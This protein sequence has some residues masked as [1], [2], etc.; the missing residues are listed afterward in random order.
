MSDNESLLVESGRVYCSFEG[1][2][3]DCTCF[4]RQ[5]SDRIEELEAEVRIQTAHRDEARDGLAKVSAERDE[6]K[7]QRDKLAAMEDKAASE[8]DRLRAV[9]DEA[10]AEIEIARTA[11]IERLWHILH[12]EVVR[13][14]KE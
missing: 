12:R 4:Y 7:T 10:W 8:V 3:R 1:H 9:L 13:E 14:E 11:D 2:D 5:A 6:L